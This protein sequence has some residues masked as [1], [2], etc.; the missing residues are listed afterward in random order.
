MEA[1]RYEPCARMETRSGP[2]SGGSTPDIVIPDDLESEQSLG[3][4]DALLEITHRIHLAEVHPDGDQSFGDLRGQPRDDDGGAHEL[5]GIDGLHETVRD[6]LVDIR[7]T[8]DVDDDDLGAV[9]PDAFQELLG[10]LARPGTVEDPDDRENEQALSNLQHRRG[11]L[12]DRL[13]LVPDDALALLDEADRDHVRDPVRRGLVRVED[14]VQQGKVLVVL[15]EQGT[16]QDV[17]QQQHDADHLLR[18]DAS[19]NDPFGEVLRIM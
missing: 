7:D 3:L 18:L 13:L 19:G 10:Q 15:L 6:A 1:I 8:G 2:E 14:A 4:L 17:T 12:P 16:G 5:R 11:Q 9:R